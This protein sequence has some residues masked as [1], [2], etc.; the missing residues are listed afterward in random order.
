MR[1]T[2]GFEINL[3]PMVKQPC[4][5]PFLS[6]L[7]S[8]GAL[9]FLQPGTI[10]QEVT[11]SGDGGAC[12][13]NGEGRTFAAGSLKGQF[14]SK[15]KIRIFPRTCYRDCFGNRCQVLRILVTEV[16]ASSGI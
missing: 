5:H 10:Q 4:A 8:Q 7:R 9:L 14:T 1:C 15:S 2:Q 13:L 3:T 11:R 16:S 6:H 12:L